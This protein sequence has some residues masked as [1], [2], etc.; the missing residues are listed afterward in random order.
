MVKI[1]WFIPQ[2]RDVDDEVVTDDA[3][4]KIHSKDT[5]PFDSQSNLDNQRLLSRQELETSQSQSISITE[6]RDE[7]DRPW[8]KLFDEY[9]YRKP[10]AKVG[11]QEWWRIRWLDQSY[12]PLERN[13]LIKLDLTV[14]VYALLG[15]W[16]KYLD[17]SNLNNAYVSGLKEDIGMKGNDL[18]DT[19]VIFLVGN[20]IF[21][22][23][24][25]FLL[26]RVPLPY[27]LFG[28]EVIWSIFTIF[29]STVKNPASLKAFRFIIGASEASFF[30]IF[31]YWYVFETS[32]ATN[33]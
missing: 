14:G 19:Q 24:W 5:N 23:P 21:E 13:L 4:I 29:T 26:P 2:Y 20:I 11:N 10:Q 30:P 31:H 7:A 15:Y 8:W 25:M 17:S 16:I 3:T 27:V 12:S 18:I 28:S 9:E 22:L 6:Y 32:F 1:P 33:Y